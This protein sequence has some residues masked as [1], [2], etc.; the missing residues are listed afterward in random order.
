[1]NQGQLHKMKLRDFH[2]ERYL[3]KERLFVGRNIEIFDGDN[4]LTHGLTL[5]IAH[6]PTDIMDQHPCTTSGEN[7]QLVVVLREHGLFD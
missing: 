6:M 4:I 7:N 5:I 3:A 1:M 2:M